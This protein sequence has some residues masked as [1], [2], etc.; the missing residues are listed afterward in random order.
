MIYFAPEGLEAYEKAGLRGR[1]MGYFASRAAPMGAVTAEV[2]IATFFN[3]NPDLVRRVIP[4]AWSLA[5]TDDVLAARL[6][7]ADAALRRALGS[8]VSGPVMAEAATLAR[9]AAEGA[10]ERLSGRP[11]FAGHVTLP[12]PDDDHLVLWHAQ[13]LLREY[14][15][16]GHIAALLDDG[17]DGVEALV[18]H[19]ATGDATADV[20]RLSRDWPEDAWDAGVERIRGRGWLE[21]GDALVLSEAGREHRQRV[22]DRTDE[23]ALAPYEVLG[24]A[25]CARLRDICRPLSRAV[26]EAGLLPLNPQQFLVDD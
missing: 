9:V 11:L 22:E 17:L 10:S 13:S 14:R 6:E 16:D 25:R 15:G 23:M 8:D 12:W 4:A 5:S 3:F 24:E 7:A 1:R 18:V 21:D 2:V 20:L 26:L 19:A